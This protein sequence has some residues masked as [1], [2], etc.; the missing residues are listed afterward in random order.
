M[1]RQVVVTEFLKLRRSAVP[2]VSLAAILCGP[3]AMALFMWII[4]DPARAAS[5]GLLGTKANL[6]GLEATWTAYG[7]YLAVIVGASGMLLLAFIVAYLFGREYADGTARNLLALPVDRTWFALGKL[8][9]AAAWW[10]VLTLI[11]IVED[12]L[13]GWA[14]GLPGYTT[15]LGLKVVM[16]TVVAAAASLLLVPVIAWITV[17]TRSYL[18]ALGF[19]L[20]MLLLGDVVGHTGWAAWFP[21]SIVPMMTGMSGPVSAVVPWSSYLVLGLTFL[22]GT[23]AVMLQLRYADNP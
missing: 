4:R 10:L 11:A 15:D 16:N 23:L 20:G 6:T 22:G 8:A 14:L 21:W 18:A 5:L 3:A 17:W 19:A 7:S 9:V 13:I 1:R 2:W 12:F